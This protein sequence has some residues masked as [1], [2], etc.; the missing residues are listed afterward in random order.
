M[1]GIGS[2]LPLQLHRFIQF[3]QQL[4]QGPDDRLNFIG[5]FQCRNGLKLIDVP[6][7]DKFR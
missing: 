7:G 3:C 1:R 4:I 5:Y 6:A 2:K